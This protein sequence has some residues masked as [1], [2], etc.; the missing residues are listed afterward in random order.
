MPPNREP[1]TAY[2]RV[3][4]DE[5]RRSIDRDC[6]GLGGGIGLLT[7]MK[8]QCLEF[9]LS[10]N[11]KYMIAQSSTWIATGLRLTCWAQTSR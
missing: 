6:A 7:S 2:R 11:C 8:L 10:V 9:E 5:T 3:V 1:G 4:E